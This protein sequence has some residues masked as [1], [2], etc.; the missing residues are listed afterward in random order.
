NSD[1]IIYKFS[2]KMNLSSGNFFI[3]LGVDE[4]INEHSIDSLDRRCAVIHISVKE[5]NR[6]SGM[7][8]LETSSQ[9]ISRNGK[10]IDGSII[11]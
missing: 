1:I 2:M 4:K 9:E 6:F 7:V 11:L 3:D 10:A 8:W 5:K